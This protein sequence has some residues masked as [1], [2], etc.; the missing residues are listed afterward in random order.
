MCL[1][2]LF[3]YHAVPL[4]V[5]SQVF[6][7]S[8]LIPLF[9]ICLHLKDDL[10]VS[11]KPPLPPRAPL[12]GAYSYLQLQG[13]MS[14]VVPS[15]SSSSSLDVSQVVQQSSSSSSSYQYPIQYPIHAGILQQTIEQQQQQQHQQQQHQQ[16]QQQQQ[17]QQQQQQQQHQQHHQ[18][19]QQQ[20][21]QQQQ[22]L[23]NQSCDIDL[24]FSGAKGEQ[25]PTEERN[26]LPLLSS[27][28]QVT[29]GGIHPLQNEM[30]KIHLPVQQEVL[31]SGIIQPTSSSYP[32]T[33][34]QL[35]SRFNHSSDLQLATQTINFPVQTTT[36]LHNSDMNRSIPTS[37][38]QFYQNPDISGGIQLIANPMTTNFTNIAPT[39]QL[40]TINQSPILNNTIP[41][42]LNPPQ[43]AISLTNFQPTLQTQ[44]QGSIRNNDL[45]FRNPK[46]K[47][48]G[49]D[50]SNDV[51]INS[52]SN[53]KVLSQIA[54]QSSLSNEMTLTSAVNNNSTVSYSSIPMQI[55]MPTISTSNIFTVPRSCSSNVQ[56]HEFNRLK[57]LPDNKTTLSCSQLNLSSSNIANDRV[58]TLD[59]I[60]NRSTQ[61]I[62]NN[63]I[64]R[65]SVD[66]GISTLKRHDSKKKINIPD[67]SATNQDLK[68]TAKL[69]PKLFPKSKIAL[70]KQQVIQRNKVHD[71]Q[72]YNFLQQER[73][74]ENDTRLIR[75]M[76]QHQI[77][78][79]P[80]LQNAVDFSNQKILLNQ[81]PQTNPAP[82]SI[83]LQQIDPIHTYVNI[84]PT[85]TLS[86]SKPEHIQQYGTPQHIP[87]IGSTGN[88]CSYSADPAAL[89]EIVTSAE[90]FS[91]GNVLP[92]HSNV[93]AIRDSTGS[94]TEKNPN[95]L[96]G[97]N[98]TLLTRTD[99][100]KSG[101]V[102]LAQAMEL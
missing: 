49:N 80:Q 75:E 13:D 63:D 23:Q 60:L 76:T 48:L 15:C 55:S 61:D 56:I 92:S 33:Q 95:S 96:G 3:S 1:I 37:V 85:N 14:R 59:S 69:L 46:A 7:C 4:L 45:V 84:L 77:Q 88:S 94:I 16:Q 81:I 20:Q 53:V 68:S 67:E 89:H 91:P 17:H 38:Q 79:R 70:H 40:S 54:N 12:P 101:K 41:R 11:A 26:V 27:I 87:G 28:Q 51:P 8:V 66:K 32:N 82:Y 34:Y 57:Q 29:G 71:T 44:S 19:Q 98:L 62:A 9:G 52:M 73:Q 99:G 18:Q 35:Q 21:L 78:S 64:M 43:S 50:I 5:G 25:Y 6:T 97:T 31:M 93:S 22:R 39:Q 83:H 36:S 30:T 90:N 42:L 74:K 72:Q 24:R 2:T 65:M 58:Y 47:L 100:S 102:E 10:E 86:I